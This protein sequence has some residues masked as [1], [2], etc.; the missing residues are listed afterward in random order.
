MSGWLGLHVLALCRVRIRDCK[1]ASQGSCGIMVCTWLL[2]ASG[3][4]HASAG[5][6][7]WV[8]QACVCLCI[9]AVGCAPCTVHC[10]ADDLLYFNDNVIYYQ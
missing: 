1:I 6:I 2:H 5:Q 4:L 7:G 10:D 3:L 8:V 9:V